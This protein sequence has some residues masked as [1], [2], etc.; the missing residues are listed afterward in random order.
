LWLHESLHVIWGRFQIWLCH[1]SSASFVIFTGNSLGIQL[2]DVWTLGNVTKLDILIYSFSSLSHDKSKASSK[3]RYPH[4]TIW[5]FLLQM[6]VSSP[7][8]N[9]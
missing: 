2:F 6:R 7:F 9:P 8:L 1:L 5:S 4:C 3:A